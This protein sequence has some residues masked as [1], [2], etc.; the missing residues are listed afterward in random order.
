MKSGWVIEVLEGVSE[1]R[2]ADADY[3]DEHIWVGNEEVEA[4]F[5]P[6]GTCIVSRG[7]ELR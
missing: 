6:D 2:H 4:W 7:D 3:C 5:Y 1:M